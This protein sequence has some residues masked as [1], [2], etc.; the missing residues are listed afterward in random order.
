LIIFSGLK[1]SEKF[2]KRA[3]M[4]IDIQPPICRK[5]MKSLNLAFVASG[6]VAARYSRYYAAVNGCLDFNDWLAVATK[7]EQIVHNATT[8]AGILYQQRGDTDGNGKGGNA[9]DG[10]ASGLGS[11]SAGVAM[12]WDDVA[13]SGDN[14]AEFFITFSTFN[15]TNIVV[16]FDVKGNATVGSGINSFDLKY[17]LT[18]PTDAVNP[19]DV[20]GTVKVFD[21]AGIHY[22]GLNDQATPAGTNTGFQRVTIDMAALI[23]TLPPGSPSID[24]QGNITLRFDDW[25]T[26]DAMSIDNVLITG[27]AIPEPSAALLG[28]VAL[29]GLLRRRRR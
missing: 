25:E 11:V 17:A 9:F 16:S 7:T 19:P 21:P 28:G 15:F 6:L 10:S 14:D 2:V 23:A 20:T 24:N 27:T 12:A 22:D 18:A 1:K 29:L 4:E 3:S 26:N 13:K 5:L 8:G